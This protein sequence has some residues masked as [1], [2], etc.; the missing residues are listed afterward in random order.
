MAGVPASTSGSPAAVASAAIRITV[1][2]ATYASSGSGGRRIG[3]IMAP[4]VTFPAP[5][6]CEG[7]VNDEEEE[8]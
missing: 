4:G 5:A 6:R 2:F 8:R 3:S 7:E 1:H